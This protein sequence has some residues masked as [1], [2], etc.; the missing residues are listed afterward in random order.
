MLLN[1]MKAIEYIY[2]VLDILWPSHLICHSNEDKIISPAFS[3]VL[4]QF[5]TIHG[6]CKNNLQ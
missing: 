1:K 3:K 6:E 4:K 5:Y 2:A